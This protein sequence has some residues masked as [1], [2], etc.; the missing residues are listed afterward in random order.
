LIS[1]TVK[2]VQLDLPQLASSI[3]LWWQYWIFWWCFRRRLSWWDWRQ[4]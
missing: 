1:E 4:H 3:W 2:N